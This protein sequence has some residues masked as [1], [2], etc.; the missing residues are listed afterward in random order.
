MTSLILS[1]EK[2]A[3]PRPV[4]DLDCPQHVNIHK[5]AHLLP[6]ALFSTSAF[7]LVRQM[8]NVNTPF[9]T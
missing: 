7:I 8:A 4:S 5:A 3:L 9:K 2:T 6:L 1:V